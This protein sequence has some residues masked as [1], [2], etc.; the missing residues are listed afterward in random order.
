M[1]AFGRRFRQCRLGY[2]I[3]FDGQ[4]E[5]FLRLA[6]RNVVPTAELS[7]SM[8]A[9]VEHSRLAVFQTNLSFVPIQPSDGPDQTRFDVSTSAR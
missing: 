1:M 4:A 6:D 2:A 9:L 5:P 3:E 7:E 8:A